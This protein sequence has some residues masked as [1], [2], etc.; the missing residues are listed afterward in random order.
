MSYSQKLKEEWDELAV[1]EYDFKLFKKGKISKKEYERRLL[2]L[3]N[4]DDGDSGDES[5]GEGDNKKGGKPS[6]SDDSDSDDDSDM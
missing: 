5:H 2:A 4:N 3:E 1:E 6:S